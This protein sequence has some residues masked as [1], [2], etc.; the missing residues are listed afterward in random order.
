MTIRTF[1]LVLLTAGVWV[2]PVVAETE[3]LKTVVN[4]AHLADT[5][6]FGF[7]QAAIAS[8]KAKVIYVAGQI[9]VSEDGPN[10]FESQVD[11]SFDNLIA[12]IEAAGGRIE[13]VVKITLLIKNHD[14]KKLQY[15]VNKRRDVFGDRPPASTLIPVSTLALESLE[16]E[17]DAIVVT[18]NQ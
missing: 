8:P 3:P 12:V 16:F 9:G 14:G 7:S 17:I 10:D 13:D 15:L 11:R 18:P 1:L 4:P 6:Q 2:S 5:T